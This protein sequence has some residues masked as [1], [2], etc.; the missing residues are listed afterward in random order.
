MK[1]VRM[2]RHGESAANAGRPTKDHASIP[3]TAKGLEQAHMVA[4]SFTN[5]PGLIVASPFLRAQATAQVTAARYPAVAFETWPI[6][7]Y[8][9]LA[10]ARCVDTTLAQRRGWVEAYWQRADPAYRDGEGAESF[11]ELVG[12]AR[13]F[14]HRLG[15]HPATD[16]AVFSHGQLINTVAWLLEHEP[17]EIDGLAMQDWR[18]YEIAN[19]IENG[20]GFF[21]AWESGKWG[22]GQRKGSS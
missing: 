17:Q 22:T 11:Q 19:H 21:I 3:L 13:S 15:K 4:R 2:V 18:E 9:Y 10:P 16:I 5:A 7:E 6:Q 14:L 12:R 8:T 1:N 20:Q